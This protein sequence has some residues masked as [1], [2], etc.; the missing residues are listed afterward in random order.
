MKSKKEEISLG[1][2]LPVAL[3]WLKFTGAAFVI[4]A[5]L[6]VSATLIRGDTWSKWKARAAAKGQIDYFTKTR[7]PDDA[8]TMTARCSLV[9]L[10]I[11]QK[12]PTTARK[13]YNRYIADLKRLQDKIGFNVSNERLLTASEFRRSGFLKIAIEEFSAI[14]AEEGNSY[15]GLNTSRILI[16]TL[17]EMKHYAEAE[18]KCQQIL[19]DPKKL[20]LLQQCNE[21]DPWAPLARCLAAQGKHSEAEPAFN[22]A[23]AFLAKSRGADHY[24]THFQR[25]QLAQSLAAMGRNEEALAIARRALPVYENYDYSSSKNTRELREFITRLD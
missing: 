14:E 12:F 18:T 1:S 25:V 19:K 23:I 5:A 15:S 21:W 9:R 3:K 10:L 16:S 11:E 22:H 4:L 24:W 6:A 13:E 17:M 7:G 2:L 20:D 8:Q